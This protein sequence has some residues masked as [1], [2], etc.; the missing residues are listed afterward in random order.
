M[1]W[2]IHTWIYIFKY[3][4][5]YVHIRRCVS[6][7]R[8]CIS[9]VYT[10]DVG[11][12]YRCIHQSQAAVAANI[13]SGDG[14]VSLRDREA[15]QIRDPVQAVK[16]KRTEGAPRTHGGDEPAANPLASPSASA[17]QLCV[18]SLGRPASW[19][20]AEPDLSAETVR[21]RLAAGERCTERQSG[22]ARRACCSR[23]GAR[24]GICDR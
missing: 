14:A 18:G 7:H 17:L 2:E 4:D 15:K 12:R 8:I 1:K 22:A 3:I 23:S 10:G 19:K 13:R 24:G 16:P 6:I 20:A 21:V 5:G 9:S 11:R